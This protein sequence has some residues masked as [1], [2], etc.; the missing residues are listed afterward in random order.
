MDSSTT[1]FP[2]WEKPSI[3]TL[4]IYYYSHKCCSINARSNA[5]M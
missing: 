1:E 4:S 5:D 2:A 3:I